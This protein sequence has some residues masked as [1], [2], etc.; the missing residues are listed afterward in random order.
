V[1]PPAAAVGFG[2]F[3]GA[4]VILLGVLNLN[5]RDRGS[6]TNFLR[7]SLIGFSEPRKTR[8]TFQGGKIHVNPHSHQGSKQT[9]RKRSRSPHWMA[10]TL[11]KLGWFHCCVLASRERAGLAG[12]AAVALI[13]LGN[14]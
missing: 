3:R 6:A 4:D 5:R 12:S 11:V 13:V 9:P 14:D 2:I 8:I 10:D 1:I 7:R